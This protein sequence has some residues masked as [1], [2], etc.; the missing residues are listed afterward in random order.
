MRRDLGC[1]GRREA[2]ID[3]AGAGTGENWCGVGAGSTAGQRGKGAAATHGL[4]VSSFFLQFLSSIFSVSS[5][6]KRKLGAEEITV[7]W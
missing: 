5:S 4:G 1:Y 7:M 2:L 3:G 6:Y